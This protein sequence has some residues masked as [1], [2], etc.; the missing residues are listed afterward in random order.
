MDSDYSIGGN[1]TTVT[2]A[3]VSTQY[4]LNRLVAFDVCELSDKLFFVARAQGTSAT[5][6]AGTSRA[7]V[8]LTGHA[9]I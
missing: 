4:T 5:A 9:D 1:Y 2:S 6:L 8:S 3:T 7:E